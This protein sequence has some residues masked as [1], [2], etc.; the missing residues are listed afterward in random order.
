MR[1]QLAIGRAVILAVLG[2]ALAA[3]PAPADGTLTARGVYYKERATRVMQPMLDGMF[4]VGVHGIVTAHFLIDAITSA[5]ASSG[6]A[7]S[8]AFTERRYEGGLGYA[9]ERGSREGAEGGA[10]QPGG[11]CGCN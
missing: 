1:L 7:D 11:G 9:H 3:S 6:A 4:D 10:G 2:V 5:S 8:A